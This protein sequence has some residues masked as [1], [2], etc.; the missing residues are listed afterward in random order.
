MRQLTADTVIKVRTSHPAKK[1][2][3]ADTRIRLSQISDLWTWDRSFKDGDVTTH[4][5]GS[6]W[7]R[8][9]P[10]KWHKVKED[11]YTRQA[12]EEYK[13]NPFDKNGFHFIKNSKGNID[14][15]YIDK[16]KA[17]KMGQ[18]PGPIRLSSGNAGYGLQHA[19]KHEPQV[20]KLG[21]KDITS[22]IEDVVNNYDEI[23]YLGLND[24]WRKDG[25][26]KKE[27]SY[28]LFRK[29]DVGCVLVEYEKSKYGQDFYTV[30]TAAVFKKSNKIK[31]SQT[32]WS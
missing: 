7:K 17:G 29:K 26:P 2:L 4:A 3:T 31:N 1:P 11:K 5:D 24:R 19:Q 27:R 8:D 22:F 6:V 12:K 25:S 15:G 18:R 32:V 16:A 10:G 20:Q 9:A 30:N 28:A 21:Y 14:F 13:K 23:K